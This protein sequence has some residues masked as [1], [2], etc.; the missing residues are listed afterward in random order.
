M[1]YRRTWTVE[2][3]STIPDATEE[4]IAILTPEAIEAIG[5]RIGAAAEWA[6][7]DELELLFHGPK[8]WTVVAR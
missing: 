5:K 1:K 4:L 8:A 7:R 2:L 3:Q 6:L